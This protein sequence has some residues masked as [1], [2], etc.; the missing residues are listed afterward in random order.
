MYV[1][2]IQSLTRLERVYKQRIAFKILKPCLDLITRLSIL[3][4]RITSP[5]L[6][7]CLN[8]SGFHIF[9]SW[10]LIQNLYLASLRRSSYAL[11]IFILNLASSADSVWITKIVHLLLLTTHGEDLF[12][13]ARKITNWQHCWKAQQLLYI[14]V[15][16]DTHSATCLDNT[17][18]IQVPYFDA[19]ILKSV[20]YCG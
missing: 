14:I 6:W 7:Y 4:I 11:T 1:S 5:L 15:N 16:I 2:H 12:S 19:H 9:K 20:L 8:A 18:V 17:F 10:F 3:S 13:V